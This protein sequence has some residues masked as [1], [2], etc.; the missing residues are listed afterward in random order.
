M[1]GAADEATIGAGVG[2]NGGTKTTSRSSHSAHRALLTTG[3]HRLKHFPLR[4]RQLL[5]RNARKSWPPDR[6]WTGG[7][8]RLYGAASGDLALL[9]GTRRSEV[10]IDC[11]A[12]KLQLRKPCPSSYPNRLSRWPIPPHSYRWV[13]S[14]MEFCQV[15]SIALKRPFTPAT[16]IAFHTD[17]RDPSLNGR[18]HRPV[19]RAAR[20]TRVCAGRIVLS[21]QHSRRLTD[22]AFHSLTVV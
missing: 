6:G 17:L 1:P 22:P 18:H 10:S 16:M 5:M 12:A 2:I 20:R 9:K 14:S 4:R 13:A 7:F 3:R 21:P 8:L 11:F 19:G 15:K